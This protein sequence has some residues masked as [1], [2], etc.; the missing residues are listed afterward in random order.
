M[1]KINAVQKG[2]S[3]LLWKT[4]KG[5]V[6]PK[7]LGWLCPDKTINFATA[8]AANT[9]AKN[10]VVR[11][12][13]CPNPYE[14][15]VVVKGK[16]I[17]YEKNGT[18]RNCFIPLDAE[19]TFVHGHPDMWG[20][21][22]TTTFSGLDYQIFMNNKKL[23][24]A[25]VYN[26]LG[27]ETKFV[28][29]DGLSFWDKFMLKFIPKEKYNTIKTQSRIQMCG[30]G[31]NSAILKNCNFSTKLKLN[32]LS[33]KGFFAMIKKDATNFEKYN[34]KY[35]RLYNQEIEK[36]IRDERLGLR[37]HRFF[38]KNAKKL[39]VEYSSNFS[40]FTK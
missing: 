29:K 21:G 16:R 38:T 33:L 23:D 15:A 20:K 12:L 22:K 24:T 27:Q 7:V 10:T 13:N 36:A 19:G 5:K 9:Y 18:N 31:Y 4:P 40:D 8:K 6:N 39:G 35:T 32:N 26:S 17:T 25:I 30:G 3:Y 2:L 14:K 28:K 1:F 34:E 37:L 11:A